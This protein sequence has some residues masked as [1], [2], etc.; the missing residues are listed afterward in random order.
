[1]AVWAP[2]VIA[3]ATLQGGFQPGQKVDAWNVD[4]YPATIVQAGSGQY[5]GYYYVRYDSGTSQ[6]IKAG[7]IRA[8]AGAAPRARAAAAN[9]PRAGRYVCMGYNGGIGMFR[10]YLTISGNAYRQTRPDL[11]GGAFQYNAG[12]RTLTFTSG[13]YARNNWIGLFSVEREGKTHKI[14]LRD[15]AAQA[16]GPRVREYANI[17]CTNSTDS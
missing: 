6:W 12:A 7:N 4:W 1:M 8:R 5:A 3:A 9:A 14:V 16:Q 10:W 11:A 15:R 2:I 17:Y 13:P